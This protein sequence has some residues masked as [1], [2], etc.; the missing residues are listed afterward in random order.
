MVEPLRIEGPDTERAR[1]G[2]FVVGLALSGLDGAWDR[3]LG[4]GIT[5]TLER[6]GARVG[7]VVAG[8]TEGTTDLP[9]DPAA[10]L[11]ALARIAE[12]EPS[13]IISLPSPGAAAADAHRRLGKAGIALVLLD[14]VPPGLLPGRDF[15]SVVTG[16]EPALGRLAAEL[17]SPHVGQGAAVAVIG[18]EAEPLVGSERERGF[19][20][21][22]RANRPDLRLVAAHFGDAGSPGGVVLR[23]LTQ[24]PALGGMF[25]VRDTAAVDVVKRLRAAG[26]ALPLTTVDLGAEAAVELATGGMVVGVAARQPWEQGE[27]AALATVLTLLGRETPAR[28]SIPPLPVTRDDV[29]DAFRTIWHETPPEAL[30]AARW[31]APRRGRR[32]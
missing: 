13:A 1:R 19:Q 23:L 14:E 5:Q 12:T 7:Q 25:V 21:W 20:G 26:H 31:S 27:A 9:T 30:I 4:R 2:R 22:I 11:A 28:I 15:S 6:Y 24:D 17:L 10:R 16:D 18:D 32:T 3:A 8:V 29:L